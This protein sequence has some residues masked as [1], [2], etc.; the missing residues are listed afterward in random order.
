MSDYIR[1]S[2]TSFGVLTARPI[3]F[4]FV[5]VYGALWYIFSP[6]TL[7]WHAVV[8]L[9]TWMMTI[10]IQRAEHRDTQAIHAK[11]DNLLENRGRR[12]KSSRH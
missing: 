11:L 3:A 5:A 8:A 12:Y 1:K 4:L 9:A 2:M 7:E 6:E 10:L